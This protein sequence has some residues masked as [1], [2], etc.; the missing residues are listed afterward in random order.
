[1][2]TTAQAFWTNLFTSPFLPDA[3]V[4]LDR[5]VQKAAPWLRPNLIAELYGPPGSTA[6]EGGARLVK[7]LQDEVDRIILASPPSARQADPSDTD[8]GEEEEEGEGWGDW[9]WGP[10]AG[11]GS[12]D[13]QHPSPN[14]S[15]DHDGQPLLSSPPLPLPLGLPEPSVAIVCLARDIRHYEAELQILL[16]HHRYSEFHIFTGVP[17]PLQRGLTGSP[18]TVVAEPSSPRRSLLSP[19]GRSR[20]GSR[21]DHDALLSSFDSMIAVI[22]HWSQPP[23]PTHPHAASSSTNADHPPPPSVHIYYAPLNHAALTPDVFTLPDCDHLFSPAV[24]D[25]AESAEQLAQLYVQVTDQARELSQTLMAFFHGQGQRPEL[26]TLGK[27]ARKVAVGMAEQLIHSPIPTGPTPKTPVSLI[28]VDRSLDLVAPVMHTDHLAD[29]LFQ[30]LPKLGENPIDREVTPPHAHSADG[31]NST[32]GGGATTPLGQRARSTPSPLSTNTNTS[33]NLSQTRVLDRDD[34]PP[35]LPY[36]LASALSSYQPHPYPGHFQLDQLIPLN[37]K[38]GLILVR[39][40]LADTLAQGGHFPK[41]KPPKALGKVTVA[42]LQKVITACSGEG[43]PARWRKSLTPLVTTTAC[44]ETLQ[45]ATAQQWDDIRGGIEKVLLLTARAEDLEGE[46][47]GP[48]SVEQSIERLGRVLDVLPDASSFPRAWREVVEE[49]EE[50]KGENNGGKRVSAEPGLSPSHSITTPYTFRV[51]LSLLVMAYS[52]VGPSAIPP[53]STTSTSD[54]SFTEPE[55]HFLDRLDTSFERWWTQ[56]ASTTTTSNSNSNS[57]NRD[58]EAARDR[59]RAWIRDLFRHLRPVADA[60][61]GLG[62]FHRLQTPG[63]AD[64]YVPLV[65]RLVQAL[66]ETD[67]TG[68]TPSESPASPLTGRSRHGSLDQLGKRLFADLQYHPSTSKVGAGIGA[69]S[70][71]EGTPTGSGMGTSTG[72]SGLSGYF[73]GLSRLVKTA[74]AHPFS[75]TQ[76]PVYLFVVGGITFWEIQQVRQQLQKHYPQAPKI[77]IGS[78]AIV[79]HQDIVNHVFDLSDDLW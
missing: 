19:S 43:Y 67:P 78:T 1:M 55:T 42:Q 32:S 13:K 2:D 11:A 74:T 9:D 72:G 48:A 45:Q 69:G 28:M 61:R 36:S 50:V 8:E 40:K 63:V 34:T 65:V 75:Q 15:G 31:N 4:Y 38:E 64:P 10:D 37:S 59:F 76:G 58:G 26:F 21:S 5:A 49:K 56:T 51:V 16:R 68:A 46:T 27:F 71:G 29:Q 12:K 57:N 66:G 14:T 53:T 7:G 3:V 60:R 47:A 54:P 70:G 6:P 33:T 52:M 25:T 23:P 20:S 17:E 35:P 73:A 22:R 41:V 77:I 62:Y 79:S 39:K 24:P 18:G 30:A 44:I